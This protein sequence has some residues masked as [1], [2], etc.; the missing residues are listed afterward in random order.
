[1]P[2]RSNV[3]KYLTSLTRADSTLSVSLGLT[4]TSSP[5]EVS[6]GVC[7]KSQ[8]RHTFLILLLPSIDVKA[9]FIEAWLLF[10][11]EVRRC[12]SLWS[13]SGLPL[14]ALGVKDYSRLRSLFTICCGSLSPAVSS[15]LPSMKAIVCVK[16]PVKIVCCLSASSRGLRSLTEQEGSLMQ[17]CL[18]LKWHSKVFYYRTSLG[19]FAFTTFF[20]INNPHEKTTVMQTAMNY[21]LLIT[22][23]LH[24]PHMEFSF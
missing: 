20:T 15:L 22:Y 16:L 2:R 14:P 19:I 1:M 3:H 8:T 7:V 9:N 12:V 6:S 21:W 17:T 11:K 18:K 13:H 24:R 5:A 4:S 10:R 23:H